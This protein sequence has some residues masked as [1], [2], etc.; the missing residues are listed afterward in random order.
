MLIQSTC[1]HKAFKSLNQ[2]A[3]ADLHREFGGH[4]LKRVESCLVEHLALLVA[5]AG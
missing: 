2:D 5:S 4:L 3:V 1:E